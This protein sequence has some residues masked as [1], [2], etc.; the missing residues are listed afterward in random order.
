M[1]PAG[2]TVET[3]NS[4]REVRS[5]LIAGAETISCGDALEHALLRADG[6]AAMDRRFTGL[7]SA[8]ATLRRFCALPPPKSA[9]R[10]LVII[11]TLTPKALGGNLSNLEKSV[12]AV[13][14]P[15]G[16]R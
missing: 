4:F 13:E 8:A 6:V 9:E 2:F 11:C 7:V 3:P 1:R 12:C 5:C 10:F 14:V 16:G 15:P